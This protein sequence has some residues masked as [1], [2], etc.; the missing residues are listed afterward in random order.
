MTLPLTVLSVGSVALG[1]GANVLVNA[2]QALLGIT[3]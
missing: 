2:V 1:L 3:I